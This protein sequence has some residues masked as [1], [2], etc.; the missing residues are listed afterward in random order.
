MAAAAL[1]AIFSALLSIWNADPVTGVAFV[2]IGIFMLA[3]IV[4]PYA[5]AYVVARRNEGKLWTQALLLAAVLVALSLSIYGNW[6]FAMASGKAKDPLMLAAVVI[7][8]VMIIVPA[9]MLSQFF[10]R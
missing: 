10:R 1:G 5:V 9:A 4:A 8:Q 6:S 3:F 7:Y 2:A